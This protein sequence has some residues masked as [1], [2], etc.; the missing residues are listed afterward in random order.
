MSATQP[1]LA[2]RINKTMEVVINLGDYLPEG[3]KVI[4]G[5]EQGQEI[6]E[7]SDI[8]NLVKSNYKVIIQL[9]ERIRS[10]SPS[11]L[12]KFLIN[13]V[14]DFGR[15]GFLERVTFTKAQ[16]YDITDDLEESIDRILTEEDALAS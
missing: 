13:V 15:V 11:F 4:A 10:V 3:E 12:E 14:R 2:K 5:R 9:P 16:R 7:Q 8:D 1:A 6:R